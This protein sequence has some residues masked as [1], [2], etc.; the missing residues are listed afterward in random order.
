MR[1]SG[2]NYVR[3]TPDFLIYAPLTYGS[4]MKIVRA[5]RYQKDLKRLGATATEIAALE[6]SIVGNPMVGD[7]VPGLE[8]IRK[9]RFALSGKGKRGGGRAIYFLLLKDEAALMIFAYSKARQSDLTPAQ[10]KE[11]LAI[12]KEFESGKD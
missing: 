12:V 2:I 6:L 1:H 7:V 10:R 9:I 4:I 11:A 3:A 8:G 5:P